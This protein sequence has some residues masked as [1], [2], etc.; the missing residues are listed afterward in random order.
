MLL[1]RA[2]EPHAAHAATNETTIRV[3]QRVNIFGVVRVKL[4]LNY[5]KR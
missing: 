1:P 4:G 5:G 2:F 3:E